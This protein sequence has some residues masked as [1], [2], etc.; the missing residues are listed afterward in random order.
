MAGTV[1]NIGTDEPVT[2]QINQL[3]GSTEELAGA[4]EKSP[5]K[6]RSIQNRLAPSEVSDSFR[7]PLGL[8][9]LFALPRRARL[10]V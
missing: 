6:K 7:P 4:V 5:K 10:Q 1:V 9:G 8:F 3:P 2:P